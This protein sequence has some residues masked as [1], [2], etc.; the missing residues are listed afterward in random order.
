MNFIIF[1]CVT[2][3][4]FCL[5]FLPLLAPNPGDATATPQGGLY[6]PGGFIPPSFVQH[7]WP[8]LLITVLIPHC[9][10]YWM[11]LLQCFREVWRVMTFETYPGL[12]SPWARHPSYQVVENILGTCA[13]WRERD[14][15]VISETGR[16]IISNCM[17]MK[18]PKKQ[19]RL[20]FCWSLLCRNTT[21]A[22][23]LFRDFGAI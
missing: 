13:L 9:R 1:L 18:S 16:S 6:P 2:L 15:I 8:I 10:V 21:C 11:L 14:L 4:F 5:S 3:K 22:L 20:L 23:V 7:S 17:K 19:V 12:T